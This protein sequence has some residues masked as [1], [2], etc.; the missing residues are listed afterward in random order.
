MLADACSPEIS[1]AF[2]SV[3]PGNIFPAWY[4]VPLAITYQAAL[5]SLHAKEGASGSNIKHLY[6]EFRHFV[7]TKDA[8]LSL[9]QIDEAIQAF[10]QV[11]RELEVI[12]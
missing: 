6:A 2:G 10:I 11:G 4:S 12:Q 7:W 3:S 9:E 8:A 1:S 5:A